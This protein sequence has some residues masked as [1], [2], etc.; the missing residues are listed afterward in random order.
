M[1]PE[2][3]QPP[4]SG[5]ITNVDAALLLAALLILTV[6]LLWFFLL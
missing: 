5:G 2:D 3:E 1:F 4:R 6:G